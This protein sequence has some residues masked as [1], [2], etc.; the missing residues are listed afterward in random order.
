MA[1][2]VK[3]LTP[4]QAVLSWFVRSSPASGSLP[5]EALRMLY[6]LSPSP[7]LLPFSLSKIKK[8]NIKKIIKN[9]KTRTLQTVGAGGSL[10]VSTASPC[11]TGTC[12]S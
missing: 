3:S 10:E 7:P 4:A 2:L 12:D 8:K 9:I 6:L 1:Q 11:S 5:A